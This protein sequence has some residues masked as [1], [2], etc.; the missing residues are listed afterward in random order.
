MKL[1]SYIIHKSFLNVSDFSL[2]IAIN[3]ILIKNSVFRGECFSSG[4]GCVKFFLPCQKIAKHGM[5]QRTWTAAEN[6]ECL[7]NRRSENLGL[8]SL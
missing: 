8:H 7:F 3:F 1:E 6:M 2:N 4:R 5:L